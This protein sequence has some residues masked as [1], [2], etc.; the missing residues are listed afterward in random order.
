MSVIQTCQHHHTQQQT[1]V[2]SDAPSGCSA[3][4][5]MYQRLGSKCCLLGFRVR[6][7]KC[8]GCP[9]GSRARFLPDSQLICGSQLCAI[10]RGLLV[11]SCPQKHPF[12][13]VKARFAESEASALNA[14]EPPAATVGDFRWTL[15]QS[16]AGLL[17]PG[18]LE[19]LR[20]SGVATAA[21]SSFRKLQRTAAAEQQEIRTASLRNLRV[22]S[23]LEEVACSNELRLTG[24]PCMKQLMQLGLPKLDST[25]FGTDDENSL[26]GGQP[27]WLGCSGGSGTNPCPPALIASGP[28]VTCHSPWS[29]PLL[30]E[31]DSPL[32]FGQSERHFMMPSDGQLC[33]VQTGTRC[34][35]D[36]VTAQ[37]LQLPPPTR[38]AAGHRAFGKTAPSRMTPVQWLENLPKLDIL[39]ARGSIDQDSS[40][41]K[42]ASCVFLAQALLRHGGDSLVARRLARPWEALP[43]FTGR[44]PA[45]MPAIRKPT[46]ALAY[47]AGAAGRPP[48]LRNASAFLCCDVVESGC[49]ARD[50]LEKPWTTPAVDEL[51]AVASVRCPEPL[52]NSLTASGPVCVEA[53]SAAK[54]CISAFVCL[55]IPRISRQSILSTFPSELQDEVNENLLI[56]IKGRSFPP[57]RDS[58]PGVA[59]LRP[60][61][62]AKCELVCD[63]PLVSELSVT[64]HRPFCPCC[65]GTFRL[66]CWNLLACP[67]LR[68]YAAHS[69]RMSVIQTCQHHHTQQQTPVPSDA[70]SGCSAPSAMY[71]R[72]GSKCCLLGFRVRAEK[73]GGCPLGSRA[74]FLPDSQLICGSQLCAISRGLLVD[75]C[76][77]KHPFQAVKA[78]FAESEAS[79][80]NAAEPPAATVGDF[81]WTLVQS[82]AGLLPPGGLEV[83][84]YG[85]VATAAGSSFRKLQR[86]AAAE[87]QEIRTA[88]LRNLRVS[89]KLEEVACSSE[90]RL[91]GSPCMKQLMQ[92]GLPKLDSTAF[93]TDDENS[94]IGGQPGWLGC[95]GGSGTNPCPP[96]LIASGPRVT[97]HS[98]WSEPLLN[99]IDSPLTFGQSERHFM[100]PSDGQLCLVQT[101]TRCPSDHVTAQC[102]QLPPPT[103]QAAGHCAFGK[104]AVWQAGLVGSLHGTSPFFPG[105]RG[106]CKVLRMPNILMT[107]LF[108]VRHAAR[109]VLP[110]LL[111]LAE[112]SRMT[113]VQWLEN[114]PKLDILLARG[115]ID[116][117][118]SFLTSASCV[119][120]A[121]ALLRHGG[122]SLVARRLARPWEALP[123]FTGRSLAIM[124]AIRKPTLALAYCAGAAGA[125][126]RPPFLRNASAFL[127]CDVVEPG[128]QARSSGLH[129]HRWPKRL[130]L[131]LLRPRHLRVSWKCTESGSQDVSGSLNF[132]SCR[133]EGY[134]VPGV[135]AH[136]P[137]SAG[138]PAFAT[139][140]TRRAGLIS[141][142][143]S[144]T[145]VVA[146][147]NWQTRQV[148]RCMLPQK[149]LLAFRKLPHS[150][151]PL[152]IG[153][154]SFCQQSGCDSL[155]NSSNV[156][157]KSRSSA[158]RLRASLQGTGRLTPNTLAPSVAGA[159]DVALHLESASWP[160][161]LVHYKSYQLGELQQL[162][163]TSNCQL[164][165]RE[166]QRHRPSLVNVRSFGRPPIIRLPAVAISQLLQLPK[167]SR[168]VRADCLW[169]AV[170]QSG[171]QRVS[172][173]C[174]VVAA[175]V[176]ARAAA[177]WFSAS[178]PASPAARSLAVSAA[179]HSFVSLPCFAGLQERCTGSGTAVV[180][181]FGSVEAMVWWTLVQ[182]SAGLLPTGGL[183]ALR[184]SG[185]ATAAC[186]SFRKL[187]RTAAAEQQEFRTASLRNLRV[188]SKLEEVAC[189]NELRLTGSPCM[190]QLMQLGLPKL[191]STA[192]GTDDENSLIGGQPGWLGYLLLCC[193]L[194][195]FAL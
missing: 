160:L 130:E 100:M 83:L 191:D 91:T 5:A 25:A 90:R 114:L 176:R 169:R 80:L 53:A 170:R 47:R 71:Q 19:V 129:G 194:A 193:K 31:I 72:L 57:A 36:H 94:L 121:E 133:F 66:Q 174:A 55:L 34:P 54:R 11:D 144:L 184:N 128:C 168:S 190:K 82:S 159:S 182:S 125:A 16:S 48:F 188:S 171:R 124:P 20:N 79:A 96:A 13:A 167:A 29:E 46:S 73:C 33:L 7:E 49:Q 157:S 61:V 3:P 138:C 92:L 161:R 120:L 146:E 1:P 175:A 117:D 113:P 21:C 123:S 51:R 12:Q 122:D 115:S 70:P 68:Q 88:S 28:R 135:L 84:R 164:A 38:Q 179:A 126:G 81:R 23:K 18:G 6:A 58:M 102:L 142:P 105:R 172:N 195:R 78:R 104:T 166:E 141:L 111:E 189:S 145:R 15:V 75:S 110:G 103:R 180:A 40:F 62:R 178:V 26:I 152:G 132:L 41:L 35:S 59:P 139:K 22:S 116:Q 65:S 45:I 52:D 154:P 149:A 95:S 143:L 192:F 60:E 9:L 56:P 151:P 69:S 147:Q 63:T 112:P 24:S 118:S 87:Q 155:G 101:G 185:V 158:L 153:F 150:K 173:P 67:R 32:T 134:A 39:L 2:P 136:A 76:P 98:P 43:G 85:E 86:A 17:P 187:Q 30:T 27:G 99:E 162:Q 183:E 37:C 97:C 177:A 89:S 93:G 137:S 77:Q 156:P 108:R 14:A 148:V 131:M 109:C 186:A 140:A 165:V 8:G 50:P 181:P 10:S 74:R 106:H 44:S 42:S 163:A 107:S 4:S 119:F 127:C 64:K